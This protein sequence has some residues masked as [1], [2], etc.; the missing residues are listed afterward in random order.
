[1]L[2]QLVRLRKIPDG[3]LRLVIAAAPNNRTAR[4][5][6]L[7]FFCPL[8][9]VSHHVH[10]SERAG[11]L[12]MG[13]NSV[14]SAYRTRFLRDGN[15]FYLPI[16]SPWICACVHA[17]CRILPLPFMRQPLACPTRISSR[18]LQRNPRYWLVIPA[19]RILA[20]LPVTEK[21]KTILRM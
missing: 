20:I 13:V 12:R 5:L 6:I 4:V 2:V 21:V 1:M 3:S 18:V 19:G 15:G 10:Y 14:R 16:I 7:K 17:L 9:H 8:P 11:A